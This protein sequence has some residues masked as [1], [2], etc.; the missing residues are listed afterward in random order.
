M[1]LRSD[2]LTGSFFAGVVLSSSSLSP[3]RDA[4]LDLLPDLDGD[5]EAPRSPS[6]MDPGDIPR[7]S[8]FLVFG[9]RPKTEDVE[10]SSTVVATLAVE[11]DENFVK[12]PSP[13]VLV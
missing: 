7:L 12:L 6:D 5:M 4:D 3:S 8:S 11:R 1:R 2:A 9:D 13:V 10:S